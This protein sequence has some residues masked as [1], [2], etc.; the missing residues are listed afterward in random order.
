M[1]L[2]GEDKNAKRLTADSTSLADL[3]AELHRKKGEAHN[4]KVKGN[5][6]PE[7]HNET[8]KKTNIWSKKNTGLI[9]RMQRDMEKRKEEERSFERAKFMLEKKQ[10]LYESMKKGKGNSTIADNFLVDFSG[11]DEEEEDLSGDFSY[12]AS[13]PDEE[14]VEYTDALGRTRQCMKKDLK[15]LQR[16]DRDMVREEEEQGERETGEGM[17]KEEPDL[18]SADMRMD[19]LRQKWEQ[20]E[21]ENLT[22]SSIHYTDMRFDEARTHGAGFYNFSNDE[23]KR[24]QEQKTLKKLHEETDAMRILKEKK[25]EKRKRDMA[26]RIKKIKAKKREKLGLP[27]ESD[28]DSDDGGE[29]VEDEEEDVNE[30]M[31]INKSVMDGLKMFR[32]NNEEAERQRNMMMR[33]AS[34]G[35]RDWD[36][37]KES[38]DGEEL[39]RTKEWKVITI[40]LNLTKSRLFKSCCKL[41]QL[42][43]KT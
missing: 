33:E 28:S 30:A 18:L 14:W 43:A 4:N 41:T 7:K 17:R 5:F 12:P 11:R 3:K 22:K 23:D 19:M 8:E 36:R 38:Q 27:P 26:D 15:S 39:G 29:R 6:R 1:S 34:S 20:Q 40:L 35:A 16:Q 25:A 13:R 24:Q 42:A 32:R 21:M 10:K 2:Y 37:D 31:D 9:V